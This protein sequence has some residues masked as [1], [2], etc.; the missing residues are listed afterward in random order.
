MPPLALTQAKYALAMF[1]MSVN[2]VP[3]WLVT[4]APRAIGVPVA[5]TPGLLPHCDVLT[6]DVLAVLVAVL[7]AV[8]AGVVE[9]EPEFELLL[10]QPAAAMAMAA[11]STIV[12]RVLC[13][14][15]ALGICALISP[16]LRWRVLLIDGHHDLDCV[17]WPVHGEFECLRRA[18]QREMMRKERG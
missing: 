16:P 18:G 15:V 5:A 10:L 2:E 1:G 3:G 8:L 4:M 6:A 12:L 13:A 17:W 7:V 14:C 11:A 9:L